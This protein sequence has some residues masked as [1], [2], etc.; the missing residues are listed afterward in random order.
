MTGYDPTRHDIDLPHVDCAAIQRLLNDPSGLD[1]DLDLDDE[2]VAA[3]VACC[4]ACNDLLGEMVGCDSLDN[5]AHPPP[6]GVVGIN[7]SLGWQDLCQRCPEIAG[8]NYELPAERGMRSTSRWI[9]IAACTVAGF[10]SAWLL[11]A[12]SQ[13]PTRTSPTAS[14]SVP[15]QPSVGGVPLDEQLAQLAVD[16]WE[17]SKPLDIDSISYPHWRDE[18][19]GWCYRQFPWVERA[20]RVLES[21]G[22]KCDWIDILV[23]SGEV[24]KFPV[25]AERLIG[26]PA[27]SPDASSLARLADYYK[28][29]RDLLISIPAG[30]PSQAALGSITAPCNAHAALST[31]HR[32]LSAK[33]TVGGDDDRL[34]QFSLFASSHL[35]NTRIAAY[36][37]A[38]THLQEA[39][40]LLAGMSPNSLL[41]QRPKD[42]AQ[43][44]HEVDHAR[45]AAHIAV[46]WLIVPEGDECLPIVASR[47]NELKRVIG[48]LVES[49]K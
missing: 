4:A 12:T 13:P 24:W 8:S 10:C 19:Q 18:Q 30:D 2:I 39:P 49:D 7:A 15:T 26:A 1:P 31:W 37:W 14:L 32:K 27:G 22:V 25:D 5:N 46:G 42:I 38:K 20:Q 28:V 34:K 11:K 3:H 33:S 17:Q 36:L 16:V 48:K 23:V 44:R 41:A 9:A 21:Q 40:V 35:A 47:K 43:L 45:H 29:N 6:E